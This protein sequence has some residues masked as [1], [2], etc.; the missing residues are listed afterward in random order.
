MRQ[1]A[2]KRIGELELRRLDQ[3]FADERSEARR[4]LRLAFKLERFGESLSLPPNVGWQ[5]LM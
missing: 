4:R 3:L 5:W 2:W 1:D